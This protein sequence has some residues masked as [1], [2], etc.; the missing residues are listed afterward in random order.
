MLCG[1]KLKQ[2]LSFG[3]KFAKDVA[4]ATAV[5]FSL[6]TVVVMGSIAFGVDTANWFQTDRRLQT[7]TDLAAIAVASNQ[8]LGTV[9]NYQGSD[10][11]AIATQELARDGVDVSRLTNL[12]VNSPPL[13]GA[14]AGDPTAVEVITSQDVT[15][16]FAG[17]F[18]E[19]TPQAQ[20]RA[21]ARTY[22][23]GNFCILALHPSESG[24]VTFS[25]SSTSFLGCGV[26]SNS[27][28]SD[29]ILATGASD[30][31]ATVVTA[32]GGVDDNGNITTPVNFQEYANPIADPYA[33][34]V[35]PPSAPCDEHNVM[36][37][38]TQTLQPGVY[39]GDLRV[40]GD[41]TFAPGTYVLDGGDFVINSGANAYG[42]DVT[43]IFTDYPNSNNV[44]RTR[45]NG[46]A[47]IELSA[48]TSGD[49]T[50]ILFMQDPDAPVDVG[51]NSGTW[52]I[53][54]N[55]VSSF[56]GGIYVPSS[57]V[58]LSGNA[59]FANGCIRLVSGAA[60]LIGNFDVTQQCN[61]PDIGQI[62]SVSVTLVE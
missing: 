2:S 33:D 22:A 46:N 36:A 59:D 21:V 17:L 37:S 15:I 56:K 58:Q 44:G 50:G 5:M 52:M 35:V 12:E 32:V 14:Y 30:V 1:K 55:L 34:L 26:A 49:Y 16:F 47:T 19:S 23:S 31:H 62:D 24:A 57:E 48:S 40:N 54:G 51:N 28:A 60:T 27:N 9:F 18:V 25:G 3:G 41:I 4:G 38:G 13:S 8:T 6:S 7:G 20:A 53:N 43:F 10:L 42:D 29:S 61:D 11:V 45:F 39:C